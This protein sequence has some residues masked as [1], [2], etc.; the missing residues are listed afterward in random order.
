MHARKSLRILLSLTAIWLAVL[1]CNTPQ[2]QDTP[3][4]AAVVART[5]TAQALSDF[6]TQTVPAQA[7]GTIPVPTT[8]AAPASP[9]VQITAASLT[10]SSTPTSA[11][12]QPPNC[13]NAARFEGET[14]P[15]DSP[16]TAGESF[17]KTWTLRNTGSCAWTPDYA[18]V[19][20]S[21]DRMSGESSLPIGQLVL[22]NASATL[23]LP[24]VAPT[25]PG[26]YQGFWKLLT[27]A[28]SRFA[29][30]KNAD[31]PFWVQI[32]VISSAAVG[33]P[34]LG[35]PD[36]VESFESNTSH[37]YL[38]SDS[39]VS[40]EIKG[41]SLVM[42]AFTFSGDQWRVAQRVMV[43]D[44]YLEA[45][46]QTGKSC[47]GEDSYGMIVRAPDQPDSYIDSGY[48]FT[49]SCSGKFRVYRLDNSAYQGLYN[50]TASSAIQAGPDKTN[51]MG[52]KAKGD[53]FELYANNQLVASFSDASY[54]RGYYG[55]AIRA[56]NTEGFKVLVNQVSF[57]QIN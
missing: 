1:A 38:G 3:D 39:D 40:F 25:S 30:G 46:F 37:F 21:G 41:G 43:S 7:T 34:E 28:G 48:V 29:L 27:P 12:T 4:V 19:F 16:I 33:L 49:F 14:I 22:P 8:P 15:D 45:Q 32:N 44:F 20:E 42:T 55:L 10:A 47:S 53:Q 54:Q 36:W 23:S 18:L 17:V 2:A 31:K 11:I 24:L 56:K 35:Q 57:W 26:S 5:L 51:I 6:L 9:T 13:T 52:I 50:W